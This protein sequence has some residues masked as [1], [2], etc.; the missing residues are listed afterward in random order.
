MQL[1]I[2]LL[3]TVS[4]LT[5]MSG[6]IVLFGSSKGHR[7][8]SFWFF[9]AA[10]FATIW[11]ISISF[12]L[13]ATPD[14]YFIA[15][16][17]ARWTYLSAILIDAAFLGYISWSEKYG[18]GLTAFFSI[19][20]LFISSLI[21]FN[22]TLLYN[23]IHLSSVGNSISMGFTPLYFV[24]L[25]Y[26]CSI[27]PAIVFTLF[28]QFSKTKSR[29]KKG[30]DLVIMTSFGISS[31]LVLIAD[32]ILPSLGY[33]NVIWL[34]PLA[35]S[36]TI[37]AFYY[38]ILRYRALNLDSTWLKIFSY[39]VILASVAII[40]MIIFAII[41]AALFRGSTPSTEVIILN[42]IM[43]L[44]FLLLMPAMNESMAFIRSLILGPKNDKTEEID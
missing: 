42:F 26:F 29:R 18:K 28:K 10:F 4:F 41:F 23:E 2:I 3:A 39:I 17:S 33:W 21:L 32:L 14:T 43:I 37:I 25:L 7:L 6:F 35:L 9:L 38:T 11:M 34:G 5:F 30:G 40:Y 27:V 22:P 24:Y 19:I 8:H 44:I 1:I 36:A 20:G 15:D 13:A 16:F 12:F 31:I